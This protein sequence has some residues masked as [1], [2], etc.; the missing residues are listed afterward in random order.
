MQ[1]LSFGPLPAPQTARRN[2]LATLAPVLLLHLL[3]LWLLAEQLR[4]DERAPTRSRIV[5]DLPVLERRAPPPPPTMP[6]MQ[7][8]PVHR[9]E[10][11]SWSEAPP[12]MVVAPDAG[13]A[14]VPTEASAAARA[15]TRPSL[16]L[17]LPAPPAASSP[18]RPRNPALSDP[19]ANTQR[20]DYA[21]RM[22]ATLGTDETM[23]EDGFADGRIRVRQGT[24]CVEHS[25]ARI[26]QLD[27]FNASVN[28]LPRSSTACK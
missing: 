16:N 23:R 21:A 14:P 8:P 11:P 7:S 17:A 13:A 6:A 25:E 2:R 18:A 28:R 24:S 19:R 27:P 12:A 15:G 3:A 9:I 5:L 1:T 26:Q 10:P 22:A 4:R 20:P